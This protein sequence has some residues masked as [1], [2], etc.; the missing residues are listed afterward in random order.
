MLTK[1][2]PPSLGEILAS[3]K[4]NKENLAELTLNVKSADEAA[5]AQKDILER[6]KT[7]SRIRCNQLFLEQATSVL[8]KI[9]RDE[10]VREYF[11]IVFEKKHPNYRFGFSGKETNSLF[12]SL[13]AEKTEEE[14]NNL[15]ELYSHDLPI[16][17]N[18]SPIIS[19]HLA[20]VVDCTSKKIEWSSVR[21]VY[22]EKTVDSR[23]MTVDFCELVAQVDFTDWGI[24]TA[25]LYLQVPE[26]ALNIIVQIFGEPKKDDADSR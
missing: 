5:A 12:L 18:R 15:R 25:L 21:V 22:S 7:E 14:E 13:V 8:K 20:I 4:K 24:I 3:A 6:R 26:T 16:G 9:L 1:S 23:L 17:G 19:K 10:S 11:Q 2:G